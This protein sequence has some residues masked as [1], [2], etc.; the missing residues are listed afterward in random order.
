MEIVLLWIEKIQKLSKV[1]S[2]EKYTSIALQ[3]MPLEKW[4]LTLGHLKVN[5][6]QVLPQTKSMI[7][8][9]IQDKH[10]ETAALYLLNFLDA[11]PATYEDILHTLWQHLDTKF[12]ASHVDTFILLI[13]RLSSKR[14]R[15]PI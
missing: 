11:L 1:D 10:Y 9:L 4:I 2:V 12:I 14:G 6:F 3:F 13:Q 15:K 7:D 8:K 5:P